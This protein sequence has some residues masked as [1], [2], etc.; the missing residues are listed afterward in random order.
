MATQGISTKP[1]GEGKTRGTGNVV[2]G[3]TLNGNKVALHLLDKSVVSSVGTDAIDSISSNVITAASH[4]ALKGDVIRM[5]SGAAVRQEYRVF[6]VATNTITLEQDELSPAPV[7]TDTFQILRPTSLTVGTNGTVTVSSGPVEFVLDSTD[8][9]VEED[10]GTPANNVPL[11]VK[12]LDTSGNENQVTVSGT[13]TV[14]S[15]LPAAAAL[16]DTTANPTVPGVG[17]FAQ[18]FNG[19]TWDRM[20]G[21]ITNGLDVDVTRSALPTG[22]ATE[23]TLGSI[24]TDTGT[25]AGDTTSIDGKTPS[26]G[27][28]AMAASVPVVIASNQSRVPTDANLQVGDA[29]NSATNPVFTDRLDVIDFADTPLIDASS[30]NGSAGAFVQVVA[31]TAAATKAI[32]VADTGGVFMGIYTGPAAS[33]VLAAQFG[34]G[35]NETVEVA[36]A[37]GTRISLRSLETSGPSGGNIILNFLG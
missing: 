6:E 26:L 21:D 23:A 32:Q 4:A 8:T 19:T 31:S 33:E 28:A 27:Q 35:S 20:R 10:T 12:L 36:I 18:L 29:D 37:S 13:V 2:T 1:Q 34:P 11:P 5:T 14:D 30:I 16:A 7:A 9:Q 15:E 17:S 25:I 24:D 22:A 3:E